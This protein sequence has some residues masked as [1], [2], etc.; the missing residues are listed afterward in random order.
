LFDILLL[1]VN[2]KAII[3]IGLWINHAAEVIANNDYIHPLFL[4]TVDQHK[5]TYSFTIIIPKFD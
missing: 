1:P 2:Y 3:N 5:F 4:Q